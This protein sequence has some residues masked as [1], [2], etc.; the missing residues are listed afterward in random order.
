MDTGY[1]PKKKT[2]FA[3]NH[4]IDKSKNKYNTYSLHSFIYGGAKCAGMGVLDIFFIFQRIISKTSENPVLFGQNAVKTIDIVQK[5]QFFLDFWT[6]DLQITLVLSK[7]QAAQ[8]F[9][10]QLLNHRAN[11]PDWSEDFQLH[12]NAEEP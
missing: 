8:A 2:I 3:V 12:N 7:S 1:K 11:K 5:Q 6:C 9:I 4:S 10:A